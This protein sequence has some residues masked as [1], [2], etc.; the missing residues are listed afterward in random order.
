MNLFD[1]S[2]IVVLE[3]EKVLLRPLEETD[4]EHLLEFSLNEPEIWR[5][6]LLQAGGEENL[7]NIFRLL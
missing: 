2:Q 1:P 6:S 4:F 3:N 7:K 5:Y